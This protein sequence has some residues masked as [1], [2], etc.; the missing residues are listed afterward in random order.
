[1]SIHGLLL[2]SAK[3][4]KN[5]TM[6]VNL[7]QSRDH[8]HLND[9]ELVLAM[10]AANCPFGVKQQSLTRSTALLNQRSNVH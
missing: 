10:T 3:T 5:P 7:V 4:V 8:N 6:R 2:Q 1:L 9:I